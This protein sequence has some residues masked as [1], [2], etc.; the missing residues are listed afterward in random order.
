MSHP[1]HLRVAR[2]ATLATLSMAILTT[3]VMPGAGLLR[4]GGTTRPALAAI[5]IL[6]I[7]AAQA[8]VL[9]AAVTPQVSSRALARLVTVFLLA[10]AASVPL[11]APLAGTRWHTWAWVGGSVLATAPFLGGRWLRTGTGCAAVAVSVAVGWWQGAPL[12]YA[13]ITLVTALSVVAVN[14]LHV[15][16][17]TLLLEAESGRTAQAR[18]E[19][20]EERLRLAREVYD[21]LGRDLSVIAL[22]AELAERDP[23][24]AVQEAA[25]LHRLATAALAR[26]AAA[27]PPA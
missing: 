17:W 7:T 19:A 8:G 21:L 4:D 1:R 15:W 10:A 14:G 23:E 24:R 26:R 27:D 6:A 12:A 13:V 25:D 9:Y 5:G 11:V 16:L 18:L 22:K 20:A 3:L 2:I